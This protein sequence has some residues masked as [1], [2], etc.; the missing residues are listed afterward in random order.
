MSNIFGERRLVDTVGTKSENLHLMR[1]IAA[2]MVIISH[3]F[4]IATGE[5]LGEWFTVITNNQLT[6]G[7]FAVSV[8]FLCGGYLIAMSVEKNK[9]AKAFFKARAI[10]L[11]PALIAVVIACMFL[12]I[13]ISDYGPIGYVLSLDTWKYLL[14][15]VFIRVKTLPGVFVTNPYGAVVNGSLWTLPV[16]FICYVL[17]FVA[18][19]LKFLEKKRYPISAPIVLAGA[20]A[21]WYVGTYIPMV[22]ELIRPVLL[23]YIGMGYW[24]YREHIILSVRYF[25]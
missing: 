25:M 23:F 18:Y 21:V 3:S 1:F 13:F 16:E 8:F 6:M 20:L 5:A 12:G 19:K 24:V 22:H 7:G 9:S 15:S 17:C 4:S 14:N 10:R 2:I 11:F